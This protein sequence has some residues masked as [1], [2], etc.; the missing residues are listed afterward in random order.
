MSR[1]PQ[2]ILVVD[3]DKESLPLYKESLKSLGPVLATVS[4]LDAL[5][6][7]EKGN[8]R[9]LLT[10]HRMPALPGTELLRACKKDHP[11]LPVVVLTGYAETDLVVEYLRL[12]AADFLSK[13]V[14]PADLLA[15][16]RR[17]LKNSG[18]TRTAASKPPKDEALSTSLDRVEKDLILDL[19]RK[20][21]G[22]V[23]KAAAQAG[24]SRG[25]FH[26]LCRKH[27]V[28]TGDFRPKN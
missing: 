3:D 22:N 18:A 19:M 25:H 15:C 21:K 8:I 4:P 23:T 14:V 2:A 9:L 6:K 13:P 1:P 28:R 27:G 20:H 26:R 24:H 7:L 16:V 10:D 11:G 17:V 5:A 12:G